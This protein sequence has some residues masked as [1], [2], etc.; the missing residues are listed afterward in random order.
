MNLTID[1][2]LALNDDEFLY[3]LYEH[4]VYSHLDE[5]NT[6]VVI[7]NAKKKFVHRQ[8]I[9]AGSPPNTLQ[10]VLWNTKMQPH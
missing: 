9:V 5:R 2:L 3:V 6:F 1:F 4:K 7:R 8:S 10:M